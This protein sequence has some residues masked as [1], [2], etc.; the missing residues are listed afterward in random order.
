M[1]AALWKWSVRLD[2]GKKYVE[3]RSFVA[4]E[5]LLANKVNNTNN[6]PRCRS[7][8]RK[9]H[10]VLSPRLVGRVNKAGLNK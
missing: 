6:S 5:G 10:T 2:D 1:R 8:E 7:V 9:E 3:R 4:T